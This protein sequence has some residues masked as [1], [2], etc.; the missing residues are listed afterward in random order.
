MA[1]FSAFETDQVI[2]DYEAVI[3]AGFVAVGVYARDGRC[4]FVMSQGLIAAGVKLWT[5]WEK[6]DPTSPAYFTTDQASADAQGLIEWMSE[7]GQPKG[8]YAGPAVDYDA[9][10]SDVHLYLATF[11]NL[12]KAAGYL[13]MPYGSGNVLAWCM[14]N[15]YAHVTPGG[16]CGWL[17]GS[18]GWGGYDDFVGKAAIVQVLADSVEPLGLS[19]DY[20]IVN[21]PTVLWS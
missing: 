14:N 5:V 11:H 12:L 3:N 4:P 7:H 17:S 8:S 16:K 18:K 21:D 19:G 13:H 9:D 10:P 6:G 2:T 1:S 20:N 15:G